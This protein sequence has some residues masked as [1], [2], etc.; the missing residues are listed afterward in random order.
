MAYNL[1]KQMMPNKSLR[2]YSVFTRV[3][4]I[5][6]SDYQLHVRPSL[7]INLCYNWTDFDEI[8]YLRIFRKCV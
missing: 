4:K 5:A 8:L 1:A 6:K 3:S 2:N 7:H